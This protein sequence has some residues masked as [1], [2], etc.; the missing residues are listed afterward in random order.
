[1]VFLFF[2][3]EQAE[4]LCCSVTN[5]YCPARAERFFKEYLPPCFKE[6]KLPI[7][8]AHYE[9]YFHNNSVMFFEAGNEK[10]LARCI[11]ELYQNPAKRTSFVRSANKIYEKYRWSKMKKKYL[12][13]YEDLTKRK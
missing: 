3:H 8:S 13:V 12:K 7:A 10:D 5:Y 1:L 4:R 6:K 11:L 2:T 9:A